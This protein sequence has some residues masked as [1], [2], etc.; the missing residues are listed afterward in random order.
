MFYNALC[1]Y[2]FWLKKKQVSQLERVLGLSHADVRDYLKCA[3]ESQGFSFA[4]A[5]SQDSKV[6]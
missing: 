5:K 2:V 1:T 6:V 4:G 3:W